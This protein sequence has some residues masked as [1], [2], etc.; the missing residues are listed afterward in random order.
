MQRVP[1]SRLMS[2]NFDYKAIFANPKRKRKI[3]GPT[4]GRQTQAWSAKGIDFH[5]T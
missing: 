5:Q 2:W 1:F 4:G 3:A